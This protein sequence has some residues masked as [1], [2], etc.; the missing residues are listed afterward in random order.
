MI[1]K[2][3]DDKHDSLT[4][5]AVVILNHIKDTCNDQVVA[6]ACVIVLNQIH[7]DAQEVK[8]ELRGM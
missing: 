2:A 8:N 4:A 1:K 3:Q 7:D 5:A 6:Q